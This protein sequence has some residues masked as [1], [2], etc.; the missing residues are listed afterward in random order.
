MFT[1]IKDG[2]YYVGLKVIHHKEAGIVFLHGTRYEVLKW[3]HMLDYNS[4]STHASPQFIRPCSQMTMN[5]M[6]QFLF[7][8]MKSL[9][10]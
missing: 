3:F 9:I 10:A 8:I 4:V 5:A 7:P 2:D 6:H 1:T